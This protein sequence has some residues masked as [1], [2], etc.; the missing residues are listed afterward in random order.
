MN[1]TGA[2]RPRLC[3]ALIAACLTVAQ[4]TQYGTNVTVGGQTYC[5]SQAADS[6]GGLRHAACVTRQRVRRL[7]A[8]NLCRLSGNNGTH[9]CGCGRGNPQLAGRDAQDVVLVGRCGRRR[10]E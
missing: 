1:A 2:V 6:G 7:Q 10:G 5:E 8:L 4:A 3:I 9:R